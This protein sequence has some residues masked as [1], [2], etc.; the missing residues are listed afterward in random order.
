VNPIIERFPSLVIRAILA[1][2]PE[3][4]EALGNEEDLITDIGMD[5]D[6]IFGNL[7]QRQ[8]EKAANTPCSACSGIVIDQSNGR[9]YCGHKVPTSVVETNRRIQQS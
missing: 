6:V 2:R 7:I 9:A 1:V 5:S 8:V 3:A 4:A